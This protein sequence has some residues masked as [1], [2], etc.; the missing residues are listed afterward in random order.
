V[1]PEASKGTEIYFLRSGR[2]ESILDNIGGLPWSTSVTHSFSLFTTAII[3]L[4]IRTIVAVF[5]G[6]IECIERCSELRAVQIIQVQM[7]C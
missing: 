4:I 5:D 3:N 6:C 2:I 7:E 1:L